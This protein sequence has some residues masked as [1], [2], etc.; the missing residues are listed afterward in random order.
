MANFHA[1]AVRFGK[2]GLLYIAPLGTTEP[3]AENV[4]WPAG[5]VPLGYTDTGSAFSYTTNIDK[6]E[7]AEEL[8]PIAY[9]TT[10]REAK[11][12]VSLAEMTL[13][14][15]NIAFNGG[16][17]LAADQDGLA[18][19]FEPPELGTEQRVMLGWDAKPDP[20]NVTVPNDL[21]FIFRRVLNGGSLNIENRKGTQKQLIVCSFN[22]EKPTSGAP[23]LKIMGSGTLNPTP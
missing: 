20:A 18:W 10:S 8:D 4:A 21:R 13:K 16:V 11:V 6:V 23:L 19:S 7:V 15:L 14:N 12:D 22:L 17:I 9:T 3:T 2:P 5:W 1:A